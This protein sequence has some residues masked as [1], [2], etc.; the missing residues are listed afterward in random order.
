MSK[1]N[2]HMTKNTDGSKSCYVKAFGEWIITSEEVFNALASADRRQRYI[3]AQQA[4]SGFISLEAE[5]EALFKGD[6]LASALSDLRSPSAEELYLQKERHETMQRKYKI[7]LKTLS[8]YSKADRFL[9]Y[10]YYIKGIRW[11]KIAEQLGISKSTFF[12]RK[13]ALLK[14]LYIDCFTGGANDDSLQ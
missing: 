8:K 5:Q 4:K 2:Y 10:G 9:I 12:K 7:V 14:R 3:D 11:N 6:K 13:T 1:H